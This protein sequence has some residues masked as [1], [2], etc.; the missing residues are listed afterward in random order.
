MR[1]S[2][3]RC[4][5]RT[6]RTLGGGGK[7]VNQAKVFFDPAE[8]GTPEKDWLS[9]LD[10]ARDWAPQAGPLIVVAPHP[11]DEILGAGGLVHS[12]AS[13]GHAV[14]V[15]SVTSGEAA[16]TSR[17]DLHLVR[18]AELRKALRTLSLV[19]IEVRCLHIPDGKVKDHQNRLRG[20]LEEL[21][22]EAVTIIAPF[23]HD[24]HSDHEATGQVAL[25]VARSY[26]VPIARYPVWLWHHTDSA[27]VERLRWGVFRLGR[28]AHRAKTLALRCFESQFMSPH[29]APIV[30]PHVLAHFER[31]FEAFV[32]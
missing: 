7:T 27:A 6:S 31:S 5:K 17:E 25:D 11:D 2:D 30:P 14:T 23:E 20:A 16:D 18:R 9:L 22:R 26:S 1:A 13:A 15:V 32:L 4:S 29:G 12:W 10:N 8:D 28:A 3:N 24:G 19:H 21:V